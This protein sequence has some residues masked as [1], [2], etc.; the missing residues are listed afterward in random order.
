MFI[1]K[2]VPAACL[3]AVLGFGL[4]SIALA[5]VTDMVKKAGQ[6]A[7]QTVEKGTRK[8]GQGAKTVGTETKDAVTRRPQGTTGLCKD[9]TYTKAK[10]HSGACSR[11]GGVEK[12]Y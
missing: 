8:V 7:G 5:Q 12:W 1:K 11:H 4:P 6:T 3:T 9:G 10:T 2:I